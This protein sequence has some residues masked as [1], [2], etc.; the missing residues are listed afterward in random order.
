MKK[1]LLF[2][3]VVGIMC[4]CGNS[5]KEETF[6]APAKDSLTPVI[7]TFSIGNKLFSAIQISQ[8]D[9]DKLPMPPPAD[10]SEKNILLKDSAYATRL[11]T[12]LILNVGNKETIS[13]KDNT[14]EENEEYCAF[15]YKGFLPEINQHVVFG[16]FIE[17]FN[18]FLID[19]ITADTNYACSYPI[20][21]PDKN[22]F[23]CGNVDLVAGFVV[24]GF[25]L[26][27][28]KD[29]KI[30]LIG[31]RELDKW[32]PGKIKWADNSTLLVERTIL[33]TT[34]STMT[35]TDYVKLLMK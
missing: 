18:Y 5:G 26:Y 34:S 21:S 9:F 30:K 23:I 33:D 29:H 10:T 4:S 28:I 17:S 22:Y 31:R 13:F 16:S 19:K 11:G 35:R 8:A 2:T 20:M 32:G 24:N 12:V 25:D 6:E 14:K 27:E 3:F 1:L 7:D 15:S